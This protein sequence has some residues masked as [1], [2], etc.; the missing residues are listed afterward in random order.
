MDTGYLDSLDLGI[1]APSQERVL[2][3]K[4]TTCAPLMA[5][6]LAKLVNETDELGYNH[7]YV[8]LYFGPLNGVTNYTYSYDFATG[9]AGS[10]YS[11]ELD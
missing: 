11:L 2:F 10:G 9:G 3:R 1:N 6:E 5:K 8:R 7:T 4:V